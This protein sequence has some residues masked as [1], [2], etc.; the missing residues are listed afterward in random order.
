MTLTAYEQGLLAV[1]RRDYETARE[2]L[3][4][5]GDDPDALLLAGRLAGEGLGAP[6]DTAE[7]RR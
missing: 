5:A 3:E 7:R 1:G 6:A 2:L 4:L